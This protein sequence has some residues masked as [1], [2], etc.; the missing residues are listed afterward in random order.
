MTASVY[1]RRAGTRLAL[2]GEQLAAVTARH[3]VVAL[4]AGAG[5]GKTAVLVERFIDIVN[6]DG[7]SPLD[8]LA[9]TYTEKAAAEMKERIIRRFEERGDDLNRRRAEAA[10]IST[11]H[12]FCARLLREN[13]LAA[14]VDFSFQIVDDMRLGSFLDE[15]RARM[16]ED[17]W[18]LNVREL[19]SNR[20]GSTQDRLFE[21]VKDCVFKSREF[22]KGI[23]REELLGIDGHVVAAM[24][25]LDEYCALTWHDARMSLLAIADDVS[26]LSVSGPARTKAHARVC[27]LL[28]QLSGLGAFDADWAAELCAN[29]SFTAGV[30]D[31]DARTEIKR[32]LDPARTAMKA[33]TLLDRT[34]EE[35]MERDLIAPLK[36]GIYGHARELRARYDRMKRERGLLD[37][38]DLQRFALRLLS[39]PAVSAEYAARFSHVL[40]DEAQDTNEV[41]KAI[42]TGVLCG[43]GQRLF[44]VGDVK[45]SIYGFRGA[46]V[47]L[48][49][50]IHRDAGEGRLQLQDNYRSRA[51][52]LD[53]VNAVGKELWRE[54]DS[55][56][57]QPL[58]PKFVYAASP[59]GAHHIE[60]LLVEKLADDP[61]TERDREDSEAVH[62]REALA[63]AQ[64]IRRIVDGADGAE[65][66]QVYDR[67]S[68][69]YRQACYGDVAI[70]AGRRTHFHV[71]ER[72]LASLGIPALA[73]GGRGFFSGREVQDVLSALR[74]VANPLDERAL[75]A[76]LR[77]PL[78][79][80]SDADLIRLRQ[81][82]S[83]DLWRTM[84]DGFVPRG[85]SADAHAFETL[86]ALRG[87]AQV[88]PPV[89]LINV[90][91]ERTAY[92]AAVL[93]TTRGRAAAA[94][95]VKLLDFARESA[96]ADGPDLRRFIRRAELAEAYLA[97]EQEAAVAAEG[98][99]VVLLGTIHGSKGLEWPVVILAGLDADFG[100]SDSGSFY[101]AVDEALILEPKDA[102]GKPVKPTSQ[103]SVRRAQKRRD[104][105][106][107]RRLF[108]VA[109]TRARE[110]LILS[111]YADLPEENR[112]MRD[113]FHAP[114]DWLTAA[115]AL[116]SGN[117]VD[118]D[119]SLGGA[120]LHVAHV[121]EESV[122]PLRGAVTAQDP[123]LTAAR[124][125]VARSEIVNWDPVSP[126][127]HARI[128][129]AV[130]DVL[131]GPTVPTPATGAIAATTV[132]QIVYFGRCPMVYY[133][134]LVLQIEEHPRKRRKAEV[135][136]Q[137]SYSAIELGTRVHEMLERADFDAPPIEEAHRLVWDGAV[138]DIP[139]SEHVRVERM[140][141]SVLA[142]PLLDR[143][144]R[145]NLLERE[146]PFYLDMGGTLVRGVIDLVFSA[147]DGRGVVVDY[148]SNDLAAPDRMNVLASYYQPQIEIYAL[149]ASK[150][151]LIQPTEATLYFL[152]KS[153][154]RTFEVGTD[155]LDAVE[156][157][158]GE[159]LARISRG[160]W[161][162]EPGEK[163]RSCGYR[164][165]GYCDVGK[166]FVE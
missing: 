60:L 79:G 2:E 140:L 64:R 32:V 112:P 109:M 13:P 128:S 88:L 69:Q 68:K 90:L 21:L 87:L 17:D 23:A 150:A 18:F 126:E 49:R 27:K 137:R 67:H 143:A 36:A 72:V 85:E 6:S 66:L 1:D 9:I 41:Q 82:G 132:T 26:A 47:A 71:Y 51:P 139:A 92:T 95:V 121:T 163:C 84:R 155:R 16:L 81:A 52:I 74:V 14:G 147:E 53:F 19:F 62:E 108:Y 43:H 130:R 148:K 3:P 65:P 12:G 86:S 30:K 22:G 164:K 73:D 156:A 99:D 4:S 158:V 141:A 96:A 57:Y 142:D 80:W 31:V 70:L 151:G 136:T 15:E 106:E 35:E 56:E 133:F 110:Y 45:Q 102:D 144:R 25:R 75:L 44:A 78:F 153:V 89:R 5:S 37:F 55:V 59:E 146:Y 134:N 160:V 123:R 46:N 124:S 119:V 77:S 113:E 116:T 91:L 152:N 40:L 33:L 165:R 42:V 48:F 20:F 154:A 7:V 103:Q 131:A 120:R 117:R 28:S 161:D 97:Q 145:A 122:A 125:A 162:T 107:G 138:D 101:S 166:R 11:I 76:A 58:V 98:E 29:T 34:A 118:G 104:E 54:E 8:I 93:R 24:Q 63:I 105:E 83:R 94:N 115:L 111:G 157:D 127:R 100:R 149:A 129:A 61:D 50:E 38:E 10:Y 39:N 135:V 159:A 114:I